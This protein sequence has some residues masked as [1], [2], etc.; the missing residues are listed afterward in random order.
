MSHAGVTVPWDWF[1]TFMAVVIMGMLAMWFLGMQ[2][3]RR[4]TYEEI[5]DLD[6][7][8]EIRRG[9]WEDGY[10]AALRDMAYQDRMP[11]EAD[12]FI[13][14]LRGTR[15]G[16]TSMSIDGSGSGQD[17]NDSLAE[18]LTTTGELS[19]LSAR[20]QSETFLDSLDGWPE[21]VLASIWG[22]DPIPLIAVPD[23]AHHG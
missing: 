4:A 8:P 23:G 1:L 12:R 21:R 17:Q 13:G 20:L 6:T 22:E 11:D 5:G 19:L 15:P 14:E 7:E 2:Y 9:L 10:D 16:E 18:R 3:E